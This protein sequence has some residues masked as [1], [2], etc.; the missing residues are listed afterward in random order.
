M[1]L[2]RVGLMISDIVEDFHKHSVVQKWVGKEGFYNIEVE[3][4]MHMRTGL[5][6]W[7]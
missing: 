1:M 3:A 5:I 4:L 6:S 7:I 2:R